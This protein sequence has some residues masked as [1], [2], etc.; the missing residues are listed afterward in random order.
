MSS[1]SKFIQYSPLLKI[2][3]NYR[4]NLF[5]RNY[6]YKLDL[7]TRSFSS[8]YSKPGD[9]RPILKS[10]Q[11]FTISFQQN[12]SILLRH[13]EN[14]CILQFSRPYSFEGDSERFSD[15]EETTQEIGDNL[16]PAIVTVPERWPNVP[17]I[18]IN[19]NPV[20]P[21][22][23]KTKQVISQFYLFINLNFIQVIKILN[24][25]LLIFNVKLDLEFA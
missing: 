23:I 9:N 21:R 24:K 1:I 5:N 15:E 16:L 3:K 10:P 4:P 18:A 25:H 2:P 14:S 20:F 17:L 6:N 13:T 11:P 22:F 7:H 8:F 19:R 12:K